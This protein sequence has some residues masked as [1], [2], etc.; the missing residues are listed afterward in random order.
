M[1]VSLRLTDSND[2]SSSYLWVNHY[3]DEE[4]RD[5][6]KRALLALQLPMEALV[7]GVCSRVIGIVDRFCGSKSCKDLSLGSSEGKSRLNW[8]MM[9]AMTQVSL[10]PRSRTLQTMI[11]MLN[12]DGHVS[13]SLSAFNF[14]LTS[15]ESGLPAFSAFIKGKLCCLCPGIDASMLDCASSN[16]VLHNVNINHGR[17]GTCTRFFFMC[18]LHNAT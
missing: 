17:V 1:Q 5:D 12:F 16:C 10:N 18:F 7:K 3:V 11:P 15:L 14:D 8:H 2:N 13:S 4:I 9:D 6:M